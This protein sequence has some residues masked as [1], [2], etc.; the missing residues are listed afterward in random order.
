[1]RILRSPGQLLDLQFE[2]KVLVLPQ[3][4]RTECQ[5]L[6]MYQVCR[7]DSQLRE[8]CQYECMFQLLESV[9]PQSF[10]QM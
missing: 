8:V 3:R 6:R 9:R 4:L 2:I 1:M 5:Q 7:C 10:E